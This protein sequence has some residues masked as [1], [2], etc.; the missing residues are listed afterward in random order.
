MDA[1]SILVELL[2]VQLGAVPDAITLARVAADY[3]EIA[4]SLVVLALGW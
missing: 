2:D 4:T 3:V 1:S